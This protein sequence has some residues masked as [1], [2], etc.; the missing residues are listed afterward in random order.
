MRYPEWSNLILM[1]DLRNRVA[2]CYKLYEN[3][4]FYIEPAFYQALQNLRTIYPEKYE[5]M[6]GTINALAAKN[7]IT[8]FAGD[9]DNPLVITSNKAV[10][11]SIEDVANAMKLTIENKSRGSDYGD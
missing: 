4:I 5:E 9:S 6:I 7:K 2:K 10:I 3:C 8:V 11:L 1:V